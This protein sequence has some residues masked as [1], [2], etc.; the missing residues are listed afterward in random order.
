[1]SRRAVALAALLPAVA[2]LAL[3]GWALAKSGGQPGGFGI[4]NVFGEVEARPGPAPAL[5]LTTLDGQ[6]V[7]LEDLRGKVVMVDFWSSWCPPCVAEAPVLEA[8]YRLYRDKGVEFVGVAIWD[9]RGAVENHVRLF[10]VSYL[11]GLDDLG[12]IAVDYGVRGIPE[13]FF[14]DREGNLVRKFVGPAS[15]RQLGG[16]LD[17]L[18]SPAEG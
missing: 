8:T 2:L 9:E 1:M 7:T 13:K 12:K 14:I 5:T 6:E 3:L 4:N 17:A 16:I 10:G 18:L 11:N 15:E